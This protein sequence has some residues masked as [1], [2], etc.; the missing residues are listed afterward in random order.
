MSIKIL[1]HVLKLQWIS[2]LKI[3]NEDI[4]INQFRIHNSKQQIEMLKE[5]DDPFD[6]HDTL[7]EGWEDRTEQINKNII[8]LNSI[9]LW[10]NRIKKYLILLLYIVVVL[11]GISIFAKNAI[12]SIL[13]IYNTISVQWPC[14]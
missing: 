11:C 7:P 13:Y 5:N 9:R 2:A 1:T 3:I 14:C 10:Y 6:I 4:E 12:E 8:K